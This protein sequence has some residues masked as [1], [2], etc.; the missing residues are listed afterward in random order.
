MDHDSYADFW[1]FIAEYLPNYY[2][3]NDVLRSDILRRFLDDEE[4]WESDLAN[5]QREF[6]SDKEKVVQ[7][8]IAL[9]STFA[10]EALENYFS[11]ILR[12]SEL[13]F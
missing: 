3:R 2:S 12:N 9:E 1:G 8:L 4:L 7:E 13:D 5:I 10:K 6:G 11:Q